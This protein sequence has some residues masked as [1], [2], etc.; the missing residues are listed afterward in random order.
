MNRS[1]RPLALAALG[2][3]CAT[4][5]HDFALMAAV[6]AGLGLRRPHPTMA[7][8]D[9]HG[10]GSGPALHCPA[11]EEPLEDAGERML[12]L[13]TRAL[14]R[15]LAE[16][17]PC[18]PGE[19]VAVVLMLPPEGSERG[20]DIPLSA[21]EHM[22]EQAHPWPE[23][24]SI[25]VARAENGSLAE[26]A[27]WWASLQAGDCDRVLFGAT[28]SLLDPATLCA[29]GEARL[30]ASQ[31]R[32]DG[33]VPGE[34]A[35]FLCLQRPEDAA[36]AQ[37]L[38]Y[39]PAAAPEPNHGQGSGKR[40]TGLARAIGE[41]LDAA[42]LSPGDITCLAAASDDALAWSLEWAQ[43]RDAHWP[44][45]LPE[46]QRL[47]MQQG[48]LEN[49]DMPLPPN[50]EL[51]EPASAIGHVGI[52]APLLALAL[53]RARLAFDW[54]GHDAI[55]IVDRPEVATRAALV[56]GGPEPA[57]PHETHLQGGNTP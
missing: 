57:R 52:A 13:C 53:A 5:G 45:R 36:A 8:P 31:A 2:L 19:R 55:L 35:V 16:M 22:L 25:H 11:L 18:A 32:P 17:P 15:L 10:C 3:S 23:G 24:L 29:L 43:A 41:A 30:L 38:L 12:L 56:V 14:E 37:T 9:A 27:E 49:P 48:T 4:G 44:W 42:S 40:L 26:L 51:L 47:A 46:E 21:W 39:Q 1:A 33:I 50:H 54:P 34:G 28:D 20:V 7:V 6:A